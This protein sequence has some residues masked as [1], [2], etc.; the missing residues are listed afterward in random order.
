MLDSDEPVKGASSTGVPFQGPPREIRRASA[1][2]PADTE[3]E[4]CGSVSADSP[5]DRQTEPSEQRR[6]A[7]ERIFFHD[8]INTAGSLSSLLDLLESSGVA[9][10]LQEDLSLAKNISDQLLSQLEDH[11]DLLAAESGGLKVA[12]TS[13][14]SVEAV[15]FASRELGVHSVGSDKKVVFG[16]D[17][18]SIR[19]KTDGTLLHRILCN[20]LKNALEAEGAGAE[21]TIGCDACSGGVRF[22]VKNPSKMSDKAAG[23]VFRKCFSTKGE[24]RGLGT[25]SIQLLGERYLKG[26]V[27]FETSEASGTRFW[28]WLPVQVD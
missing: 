15:F 25:Y 2:I 4:S 11:R 28:L 14:D 23:W 19:L 22:W 8:I 18:E 24:G 17:C 21:V 26:K 5:R 27:G 13:I 3:G 20:M 6:S 10:D 1:P 16:D 7:I 12:K 9:D